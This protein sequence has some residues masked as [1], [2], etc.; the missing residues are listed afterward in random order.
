MH[1]YNFYRDKY[2]EIGYGVHSHTG[3][4]AEVITFYSGDWCSRPENAKGVLY[5]FE[6]L[7]ASTFQGMDF[8]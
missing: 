1:V 2:A 3:S 5:H 7:F 6:Y 8:L 4:V